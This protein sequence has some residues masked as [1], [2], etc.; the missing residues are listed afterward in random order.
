M[1]IDDLLREIEN[2]F[3][4]LFYYVEY[5][6][7]SGFVIGIPDDFKH[8]LVSTNMVSHI[9]F[10]MKTDYGYFHMGGPI[11]LYNMSAEQIKNAIDECM[12][13]RKNARRS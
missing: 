9:E 2:Q 12:E 10:S 8:T 4:P 5:A 1:D 6:K 3:D 11:G 7:K 13:K